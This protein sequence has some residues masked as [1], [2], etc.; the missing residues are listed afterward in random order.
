VDDRATKLLLKA[1]R[2]LPQ[3]EQDQL[4]AALLRGAVL[5]PGWP[6]SGSEPTFSEAVPGPTFTEA[7]PGPRNVLTWSRPGVSLTLPPPVGMTGPAA[8]LPVRLP[9]ELHER[10]RAW[11][12][13]HGFSMASVVRGLVERFLDEQE[14]KRSRAAATKAATATRKP[15]SS[16]RSAA[17]KRKRPT[18]RG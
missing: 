8:M 9:P 3:R 12:G 17:P 5:G 11:S 16:S 4:L 7:V 13:T 14:G 18:A 6:T 2:Q 1:V 15:R 10:L